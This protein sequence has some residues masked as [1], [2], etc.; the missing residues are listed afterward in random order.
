MQLY[1]DLSLTRSYLTSAL[2]HA[3]TLTDPF[4]WSDVKKWLIAAAADGF[5][6]GS[7][8][9][10]GRKLDSDGFAVEFLC[11]GLGDVI[12][13]EDKI[14]VSS[15]RFSRSSDIIRFTGM[16]DQ[17]YGL[18]VL[19]TGGTPVSGSWIGI[20]GTLNLSFDF[21]GFIIDTNQSTSY[22]LMS[23][24]GSLNPVIRVQ[25]NVVISRDAGFRVLKSANAQYARYITSKN[26]ILIKSSS[27]VS[28][29]LVDL[30]GTHLSSNHA[31]FANYVAK[32]DEN[33]ATVTVAVAESGVDIVTSGNR[34]AYSTGF[35][36]YVGFQSR[37]A[38]A[39]DSFV[40]Y[41][42]QGVYN[43]T[44]F[45][46][47]TQYS[48][49]QHDGFWPAHSGVLLSTCSMPA[50]TWGTLLH[51][52]VGRSINGRIDAGAFQKTDAG[53]VDVIHV[54]LA[55]ANHDSTKSGV[56]E[57]PL[58][59]ADF[60][61][62]YARRAPVDNTIQYVL[63]NTNAVALSSWNLG[64]AGPNTV[65]SDVSYAG[66]GSIEI[67]SYRKHTHNQALLLV[68]KI[69]PEAKLNIGFDNVRFMW[70][71][72]DDWVKTGGVTNN[73]FVFSMDRC[74][75][76]STDACTQSLVDQANSTCDV[77]ISGS[78]IVLGHTAENLDA[79]GIFVNAVGSKLDCIL[80]AIVTSSQNIGQASGTANFSAC[81]V[82]GVA[83]G[84]FSGANSSNIRFG[85]ENLD[86][87]FVDHDNSDFSKAN[88]RLTSD[89]G[90]AHEIIPNSTSITAWHQ[91]TD[92]D[93][94]GLKRDAS[95]TG[96]SPSYDAG[97]YEYDY[98]IPPVSRYYVDL[99]RTGSGYSGKQQS[100]YSATDM[101]NKILELGSQVLDSSYEFVLSGQSEI[102]IA[103]SNI[104]ALDTGNITFSSD[105]PNSPA[106]LVSGSP[107]LSI[108]D[109]TNARFLLDGIMFK[110][111]VVEPV[112]HLKSVSGTYNSSLDINRSILWKKQ[113]TYLQFSSNVFPE[114]SQMSCDVFTVV[115]G[116][117]WVIGQTLTDTLRNIASGF[118]ALVG[119]SSAFNCD[120]EGNKLVF[121]SLTSTACDLASDASSVTVLDNTVS[122]TSISAEDGW[123]INGFGTTLC[124]MFAS[125]A[126]RTTFGISHTSASF[127]KY[128]ALA[129]Q[130]AASSGVAAAGDNVT[131]SDS[132]Y[133]G[134]DAPT[135][136]MSNTSSVAQLY[137]TGYENEVI[138]VQN[139]TL[140]TGYDVATLTQVAA[141]N[142][143]F[144]YTL[145]IT[146]SLRSR[147]FIQGADAVDVGA[148]EFNKLDS[149]MS[150]PNDVG[151]SVTMLTE[152]GRELNIRHDIDGLGFKIVGYTL[153]NEG[154][155][156]WN[157]VR[158][159]P[160]EAPGYA[161]Y[162][163]VVI[164]TNSF[165]SGDAVAISVGGTEVVAEYNTP[166]GFV[167]GATITDTYK[168][169]A[170]SL[171]SNEVFRRYCYAWVTESD[172]K[173][174][175]KQIGVIGNTYG[176]A[177]LGDYITAIG[178]AHGVEPVYSNQVWPRTSS[179][180]G[181]DRIETPDQT[182]K[183]F[184]VRLD[185]TQANS[186]IGE[187]AVIAEIT[188]SSIAWEVGTH[189]VYAVSRF[190]LHVK[191]SREVLVKRIIFQF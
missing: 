55:A 143:D 115:R 119:F 100:R 96:G 113:R 103:I 12:S 163:S 9:D 109:C 167:A 174:V 65:A 86:T 57:S 156:F 124:E 110:S 140:S 4:S 53:T 164:S 20:S 82:N 133:A 127:G 95:G 1:V 43:D 158:P 126:T 56:E 90:R 88:F 147:V 172:L 81:Y 17:R 5:D 33:V 175:A 8:L 162:A 121:T 178:F 69:L 104:T 25:N 28:H 94:R 107:V 149:N 188:H 179:H 177:V 35:N 52:I 85:T 67:T 62:D 181:F 97:A 157:P 92:Y 27:G 22:N 114:T 105:N 135:C 125:G 70:S 138:A 154:Y 16:H 50:N 66:N 108:Q 44:F 68:N 93:A 21:D 80:N 160:I 63:R 129:L 180:A 87:V 148:V 168:N 117:D 42:T 13:D 118:Q 51:D 186:P 128:Q 84:T 23:F 190:G 74:V 73:G 141:S 130:G 142:F 131:I 183:S 171:S 176:I 26:S 184:V 77:R 38:L 159:A 18:P 3:G 166:G 123:T 150:F 49:F 151:E 153:N 165:L 106:T 19:T 29:T 34:Y 11:F 78:T 144:D 170:A 89:S 137:A 48:R 187:F 2:E 91:V 101:Q 122:S 41:A 161:A 58:P 45:G 132:R 24:A 136:T 71:S 75:I 139:F 185:T 37:T 54:D 7:D 83:S 64:P 120:I 79:A 134:F 61:R 152:A 15:I 46:G 98:M 39:A 14:N 111:D 76:K 116:T 59:L 32:H 36:D 60:L 47:T 99:S 191:H 155:V 30:T 146:G 173:I 189:V 6:D 169:I 10:A 72:G 102:S 40:D 112:I 31:H 145:D 182:T